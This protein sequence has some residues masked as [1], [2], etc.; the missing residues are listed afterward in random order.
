MFYSVNHL[1]MG[2]C[3]WKTVTSPNGNQPV[4]NLFSMHRYV[5]K[6][7]RSNGSLAIHFT[8]E[9]NR[10]ALVARVGATTMECAHPISNHS[11]S[12]LNRCRL[13]PPPYIE[14]LLVLFQPAETYRSHQNQ[15][16]LPSGN[17]TW[18][19][20]MVIYSWFSHRKKW[21]SIA[22]LNYHRV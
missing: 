7:T 22:M 8:D 17:L 13:M 2:H 1:W 16:L 12:E 21:F 5:R 20:K 19:W 6:N 4:S 15:W 10:T 3:P 11:E 9:Q 14:E 18:L